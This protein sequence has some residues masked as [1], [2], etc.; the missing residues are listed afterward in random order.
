[1][2]DVHLEVRDALTSEGGDKTG[3]ERSGFKRGAVGGEDERV[4]EGMIIPSV[5]PSPVIH[6]DNS[7]TARDFLRR[8]SNHT[9]PVT[10]T[11]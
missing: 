2:C 1:M 7:R 9:I 8:A 6:I 5:H 11:I 3:D 10:F 4:M